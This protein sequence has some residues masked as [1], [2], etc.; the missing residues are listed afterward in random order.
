MLLI[1]V[2]VILMFL[3]NNQRELHCVV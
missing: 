2:N 1:Y 3:Q